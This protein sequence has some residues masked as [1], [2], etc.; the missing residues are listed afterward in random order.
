MKTDRKTLERVWAKVDKKE[1]VTLYWPKA[2]TMSLFAIVRQT[3]PHASWFNYIDMRA[4][5]SNIRL[6]TLSESMAVNTAR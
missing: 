3:G 5:R 1:L 4:G 6:K 2:N